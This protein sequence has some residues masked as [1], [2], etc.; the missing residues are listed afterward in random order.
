MVHFQGGKE[1][2]DLISSLAAKVDLH[3]AEQKQ[4]ASLAANGGSSGVAAD[5]N[6]GSTI[7]RTTA[8]TADAASAFSDS[9]DRGLLRPRSSSRSKKQQQPPPPAATEAKLDLEIEQGVLS[10]RDSEIL[11]RDRSVNPEFEQC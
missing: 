9:E 3:K 1:L 10:L 4:L 2:L 7:S 5:L 8:D 6:A 11:S